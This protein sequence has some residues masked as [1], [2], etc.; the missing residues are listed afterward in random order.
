VEAT[1]KQTTRTKAT[2]NAP[3]NQACD[4]STMISISQNQVEAKLNKKPIKNLSKKTRLINLDELS[5]QRSSKD[6]Q[7]E[8]LD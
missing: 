3:L 7:E 5:M 1:E 4:D 2:T 6:K 8:A